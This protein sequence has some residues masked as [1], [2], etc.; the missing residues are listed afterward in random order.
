MTAN[1]QSEEFIARYLLG[2]LPEEQQVE[3]EN[4]AFSDPEYLRNI[5]AVENDLI[6]E[7]VRKE[8]SETSSRQFEA[9]FMASADR[10]RRVEFARALATIISEGQ[11][12]ENRVQTAVAPN[13]ITW[14]DSVAAFISG[15]APAARL[16]LATAALLIAATGV[17]LITQSIQQRGELARQRSEQQREKN[18][19]EALQQQINNERKR[20]DELTAQLGQEREQRQKS[21]ELIQQLQRDAQSPT[22]P[23]PR[24][25]AF[26]LALLPGISRSGGQRPKLILPEWARLVRLQV[27]LEPEEQYQTFRVEVRTQDGRQVWTRDDLSARRTR[28]G[29]T[30]GLTLPAKVLTAGQYELALKG[31]TNEGTTEDVGYYYFEVLKK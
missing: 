9:R 21:D 12:S 30:I 11:V 5:T 31:V 24:N 14:R 8:L 1:L 4:R 28:S 22:E 17:W 6:D 27:G 16:S 18:D 7:Y 15:L 13:R 25:T 26:S 29:K 20:N 3:I 2:D 10:R 19:R 23:E